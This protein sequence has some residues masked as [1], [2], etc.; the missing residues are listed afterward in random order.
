MIKIS[1]VE[2]DKGGSKLLT[3]PP[4]KTAVAVGEWLIRRLIR[5]LARRPNRMVGERDM[6]DPRW[7]LFGQD[8]FVR[9]RQAQVVLMPVVQQDHHLGAC[10]QVA[11]RDATRALQ[12]SVALWQRRGRHGWTSWGWAGF[13]GLGGS[14][15]TMAPSQMK[16]IIIY[17]KNRKLL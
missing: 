9:P 2:R 4:E 15:Q 5:R 1:A 14:V 10:H 13:V 8:Q 17:I 7:F 11:Y 12:R 16:I 6:A 3:G